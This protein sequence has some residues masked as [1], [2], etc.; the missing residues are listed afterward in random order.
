V[1]ELAVSDDTIVMIQKNIF[2]LKDFLDKNPHLFHSA[3]GE[4]RSPVADQEAWKV[5]P[6]FNG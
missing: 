1:P 4:A 3:P 6:P 2:Y 5:I